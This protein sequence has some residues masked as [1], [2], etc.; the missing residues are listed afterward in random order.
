MT[1]ATLSSRWARLGLLTAAERFDA[2]QQENFASLFLPSP[3][4]EGAI[5]HYLRDQAPVIRKPRRQVKLEHRVR[6]LE[7][8][9]QRWN[10][11]EGNPQ[12]IAAVVGLS[13][14]AWKRFEAGR[15]VGRV[16]SLV[17]MELTAD[18]Q[19][20]G[21]KAA[22]RPTRSRGGSCWPSRPAGSKVF[23]RCPGK[24]ASVR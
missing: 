20:D 17:D 23:G 21:P 24:L 4:S 12:V 2:H 13:S 16:T 10:G 6:Q 15:G 22:K 19:P 3:T 5:L 11:A 1:W 9:A 14:D 8:M 7:W 18:T